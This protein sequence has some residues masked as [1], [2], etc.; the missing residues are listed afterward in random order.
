MKSFLELFDTVVDVMHHHYAG[1]KDKK[2]WDNPALFR[3]KLVDLEKNGKLNRLAFKEMVDDYLSDFKDKH[4]AFLFT[5]GEERKSI[6]FITRRYK[7]KLYVVDV[8][9]ENQLKRGMAIVAL[10]NIPILELRATHSRLLAVSNPVREDWGKLLMQ[11]T[12]CTAE[13]IEG[14]MFEFKLKQY[15]HQP[16][17]SNYSCE[18]I[19]GNIVLLKFNNFQDQ[20]KMDELLKNNE[21]LLNAH[22]HLIIDVRSNSGGSDHVFNDLLNYFFP[23]NSKLNLDH[24]RQEQYLSARNISNM[25]DSLEDYAK[26]VNNPLL[27]KIID[28]YK[29]TEASDKFVELSMSDEEDIEEVVI[30][31]NRKPKKTVVLIDRYCGSAGDNFAIVASQSD[32]VTLIGRNTMGVID[33]ANVCVENYEELN[34]QL[35]YP[36]SRAKRI[37]QGYCIDN[38]G[39][40]PDIS[41]EWTPE[42]LNHDVDLERAIDYLRNK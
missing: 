16:S 28:I 32:Y 3:E 23:E 25:I 24:L 37:D 13:D 42:N 36:I 4:V 33:Y 35:L 15:P 12:C 38:I 19:E 17:L 1:F 27:Y 34:F 10:D 6:G 39:F 29:N 20:L 22:E 8:D 41:I 5:G 14:N 30:A 11:S 21:A 2:N 31:G 18:L 40:P 9:Q 7:E 26:G